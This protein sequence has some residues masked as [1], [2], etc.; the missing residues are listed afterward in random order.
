MALRKKIAVILSRFPYP[1]DKGDKLRAFHQIQYLSTFHDIY[2]FV[3]TEQEI[4]QEHLAILQPIC[5]NITQYRLSL[6][7]KI[8]QIGLS[9]FKQ[10]PVQV[11]Y[12]FS[13]SIKRKMHLDIHQLKPNVVYCQLSRT[14]EYGKNLP[15]P[16]II[17][18]QDAFSTNYSRIKEQYVGPKKWFYA[19]ESALMKKYEINML[20]WFDKCTII[21]EFD[22]QEIASNSQN[23]FVVPNGVDTD[24]FKT[25]SLAKTY[26]ILFLGNLSYIPNRQAAIYL[27]QK[28]CPLLLAYK[29]DIKILIAGTSP[30]P[31]TQ[32][33]TANIDIPGWM[34]DIRV[35][36]EKSSIFVAPL[37][38]GAGLQNKLL[39][40]MSMELPCI[41]TP[42]VNLSLQ[43]TEN[44]EILLAKNE[45]EFVKQ[46]ISLLEDPTLNTYIKSN[47][48]TFV[49]EN[50]PWNKANQKLLELI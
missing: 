39:E 34:P 37:F 50:Y 6:I 1:L 17:D 8:V 16:K 7:D 41:T 38:S 49:H 33:A 32:Y 12:F 30:G 46:I 5:K 36:Y 44:K 31:L 2:L 26:D 25:K 14:A 20:T 10:I 24:Y 3:L 11:G 23:L 21:S 4:S 35:A 18:F 19:R 43:A 29:K 15:Y 27:I 42:I 28:I 9:A 22:R 45:K 47:A 40:A 13:S 48:S